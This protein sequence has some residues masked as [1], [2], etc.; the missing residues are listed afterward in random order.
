MG[1][2]AVRHADPGRSFSILWTHTLQDNPSHFDR[3]GLRSPTL[4]VKPSL[5]LAGMDHYKVMLTRPLFSMLDALHDERT[6]LFMAAKM[7]LG[8]MVGIEKLF[9]IFIDKFAALTFLYGPRSSV[10]STG[11]MPKIFD[12][13]ADI[14]MA[15]YFL[16]TLSN[17]LRWAPE[18]FWGV[19]ATRVIE[20]PDPSLIQITGSEGGF[21]LQEFF[22][23]LCLRCVAGD[24]ANSDGGRRVAVAQLHR[25][26]LSLM[27]QLLASPHTEPLRKLNIQDLLSE[28]LLQSLMGSDPYIQ[29]MLMDVVISAI[30]L[31]VPEQDEVPLSPVGEKRSLHQASASMRPPAT[32]T[33]PAQE[34]NPVPASLLQCIQ[35]ALVSRNS[36]SVLD[37]WVAFLVEVLPLYSRSI[38]QVL[39]P[40]V[41]TLCTQVANTFDTLRET[42]REPDLDMEVTS[43]PETTLISLLNALEQVL[44]KA[45]ECLLV[46]ESRSVVVKSP[47]QPQ[48]FFGNMVSGV[49]NSEQQQTRSA[50]ANDRLTVLLAFQDAVRICF[51]IWSWGQGSEASTLDANS[52]AS[53]NYTSLRMRNR[54]RRLLEHVF[55]AEALECLET[56]V[57][58]WRAS[59]IDTD[60]T[61]HSAVFSLLPVLDG[62]RPV[63]TIPAIFNAIYSRSNPGALEP[64]R[65]ST[66]TISLQDTD[67]VIFLVDYAK[68]LEDDAM[69]EIWQDCMTFLRDLLTNPFPHRQ[70]LPSL[71]KFAAILGEKVDNTN[72]GEQ[73]RMRRELGDIFLRL[74]TALFTTRPTTFADASSNDK[75]KNGKSA[76][77]TTSSPQYRADDVVGIL[78]QIVPSL[79]KILVE[80]DRVLTAAGTISANVVGPGIRSKGFPDTVSKNMLTLLYE[81][82]RL[83]NNQKTWKKDIGDAFN[84]PRFFSAS[85]ELV[86]SDWLPLLH[87]WARSDKER[88]T[89]ILS[90]ITPPTTAGIVFGVGATS[91]RLEAD[92]KTQLNL[93]RIATLI[94]ASGTDV[95][96]ADLPAILERLVE[97]LAA[98]AT[99][100]PSSTTRAE[101]YMV[102][103]ALTLRTSAVH[104]SPLWPIVNSEIHEAI[105][106]VVATGNGPDADTFNNASVLQ[107]CKL[108]DVLVTVAPDDFQLHEWLFVTD[109]IDAIYRS[110]SYQPVALVDE[111]SEELGTSVANHSHALHVESGTS[112]AAASGPHRRPLLGPGGID[113]NVPFESKDELVA[114]I[115]RPFFGQLSIFLFESTYAMSTLDE[116]WCVTSL[117]RDLFDERSIVKAL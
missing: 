70:T 92:R 27:Q 29:V 47:D 65:K 77:L 71:L 42:F 115:L 109:T 48:G 51:R 102:I 57:D 30:K 66:L 88:I 73:K 2:F 67:L 113:V 95:F 79:P 52:A 114:K 41:E 6:Q 18:A 80:S 50:T 117:L 38:F 4:E 45:H 69:D 97:L 62:S 90:R 104:L 32:S 61:K 60:A 110:P 75:E 43:A 74:L 35:A 5:R 89:E 112:G 11:A 13:E 33:V 1:T 19:L 82:T 72:F 76:Q 98:T 59:L 101:I 39:I 23:H 107:A 17:V 93:R 40:L 81:L 111:L 22:L 108:L 25:S 24:V 14:D 63:N 26:A 12:D 64:S 116:E 3:R 49:F 31:Q 96:V 78:A 100:S 10:K 58:I 99:S 8:S 53:F 85:T 68:S 34:P 84:D 15:V 56:V 103:R 54:A 105:S 86:Q 21:S 87:Q 94:M 7:W 91:A 44:A 28:R 37:S 46:E 55:A 36:R 106:S 9:L 16:R 83:Q 20:H